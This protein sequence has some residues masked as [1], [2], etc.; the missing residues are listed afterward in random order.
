MDSLHNDATQLIFTADPEAGHLA[1]AEIR[2][3]DPAA[4]LLDWLA[5]GVGRAELGADWAVLMAAL[6][7]HPPLFCRHVCPVQASLPLRPGLDDLE[8]LAE[9]AGKLLPLL[10]PEHSFS[11]QARL[12]GDGFP[13]GRFNVNQAV[14]AVL[15]AAGATLDV[16]QP[17]QVFSVVC[18]PAR[19]YLGLSLAAE[20]LS[21]WAG[22]ERRFKREAGQISRAEF[23]L[24]EALELFRVVLPAEGLALDL[25]AAPGGWTRVLRRHALQVVAVDP[26]DLHPLLAED[27]AVIHVRSLAHE[28]LRGLDASQQFDVILN[29]IRM[30]ARDSARL[31][32]EAA[33][34]L[35]PD[36]LAVI[37]LKLPGRRMDQVA[38]GA[39]RVLQRSY[40]IVGA[41]QLFHNRREI[42]AVLRPRGGKTAL[43]GR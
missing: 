36:G 28:Y 1:L 39:L 41:R 19:A 12:L 40:Q 38:T 17:E 31:M 26:A 5:P 4:H 15:E 6:R 23:K 32:A 37:A 18:T 25:G 14:A 21:D 20:N 11:V 7:L 22:G 2:R 42:T 34:Y 24:L 8:R 35:K 13:Y 30:D 29:D 43:A 33:G 9:T 27:P 10:E 16:R 3:T